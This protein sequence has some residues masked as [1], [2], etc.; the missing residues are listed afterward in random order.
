VR[1]LF[2]AVFGRRVF[3]GSDII[4]VLSKVEK[5]LVVRAGADADKVRILPNPLDPE[6]LKKVASGLARDRY[7]L[8]D[9]VIL[10]V[11]RLDS[12]KGLTV[13]LEAYGRLKESAKD[14]SLCIV[15]K[16]LNMGKEIHRIVEKDGLEDVVIA[17]QVDKEML[18]S[19]YSC[20]DMLVLPSSYEA[21][22]MVLIEAMAKGVPVIGTNVGG[23]PEVLDDDRCGLMVPY[24][25]SEA[26]SGAMER[27]L[28]DAGLR[29]RLVKAGLSRA[30]DFAPG[31][32]AS[33]LRHLYDEVLPG[34][35]KKK[36]GGA[37]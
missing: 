9:H 8:K 2:D 21:F 30:G 28:T 36:G 12:N 10:F 7:R 16:D 6:I 29:E 22:G 15:G 27:L 19:F 3:R 13:L 33:G 37:R 18:L 17:G 25:D 20:A 5:E 26:L 31:K 32:V 4:T 35:H 14:V 24:G 1:K 11:G 23:I 34:A